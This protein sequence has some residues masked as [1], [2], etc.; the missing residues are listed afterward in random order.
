M[1]EQYSMDNCLS[2]Y[3]G[4]WLHRKTLLNKQCLSTENGL[5]QQQDHTNVAFQCFSSATKVGICCFGDRFQIRG[6]L[7]LCDK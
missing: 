1:E 7:G 5:Q 6:I 4:M 2:N 3:R